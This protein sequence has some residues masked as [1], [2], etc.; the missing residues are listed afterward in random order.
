MIIT[1]DTNEL[2]MPGGVMAREL[3]DKTSSKNKLIELA[4]SE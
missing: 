4:G 2:W 3:N 1:G